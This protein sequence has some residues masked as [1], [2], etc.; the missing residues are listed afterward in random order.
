MFRI[1][2]N[3]LTLWLKS[4][5]H[6]VL[7]LIGTTRIVILISYFSLHQ[8]WL[9]HPVN[10]RLWKQNAVWTIQRFILFS[11]F[12]LQIAIFYSP[13]TIYSVISWPL[14]RT[15]WL[16]GGVPQKETLKVARCCVKTAFIKKTENYMQWCDHAVLVNR[17][18][19]NQ[20]WSGHYIWGICLFD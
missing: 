11:E 9:P 10:L 3:W 6:Q 18:G 17:C 12:F 15:L 13:Y 19:K 20:E 16:F 8:P 5:L 2:K 1:K 4:H 7:G 14:K